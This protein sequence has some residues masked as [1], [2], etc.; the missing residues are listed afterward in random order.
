MSVAAL[1]FL[2]PSYTILLRPPRPVGRERRRA[3]HRM[4]GALCLKVDYDAKRG[5][6][7]S[8]RMRIAEWIGNAESGKLVLNSEHM[9]QAGMDLETKMVDDA[10][11]EALA[12]K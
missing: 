3:A 7:W 5:I 9:K 10:V 1:S 11:A 8:G 2:F 6:L 4:Q 12:S